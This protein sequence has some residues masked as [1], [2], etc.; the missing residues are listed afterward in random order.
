M[1]TAQALKQYKKQVKK[2]A[3]SALPE[4][5]TAL[6]NFS[7]F[8]RECEYLLDNKKFLRFAD[9]GEFPALS[10][11]L[12][13]LL[14]DG[15]LPAQDGLCRALAANDEYLTAS[16]DRFLRESILFLLIRTAA[17][18]ANQK[19][20]AL[21]KN[22]FFSFFTLRNI[23]FSA[24]TAACCLVCRIYAREQA[25]V[26]PAM[27]PA[28]KDFYILTTD[29]EAKRRGCTAE[30]LAEEIRALADS[31]GRHVGFYLPL[32]ADRRRA[33][34][35]I[36]A[37]S[38]LAGVIIAAA[39]GI[40][41]GSVSAALLLWL[42]ITAVVTELIPSVAARRVKPAFIPRME[43][44]KLPSA[45]K[46]TVIAVS[47]IVPAPDKT[48]QIEKHLLSLYLSQ[49]ACI[50]CVCLSADFAPADTPETPSDVVCIDALKRMIDRL[51]ERTGG[52]FVLAVRAR[53]Y[54]A[55][56]GK[57]IGKERKRG[58]LLALTAY[59]CT[60]E[61]G[62]SV[63]H[64]DHA[65]MRNAPYAMLLDADTGLP[66]GTLAQA[67][68]AAA[69]P[70]HQPVLRQDTKTVE[71]GYGIF[72]FSAVPSVESMSASIFSRDMCG[73]GGVSSYNAGANDFYGDFFADGIFCGKGLV[74][75]ESYFRSLK[76]RFPAEQMLSH[77]VAEGLVLRV[78][79]LTDLA[80]TDGFPRSETA[81]LQRAHRWMRGDVQNLR[82]PGRKVTFFGKKTKTPFGFAAR[83]KLFDNLR[84][85]VT[86][87]A[88]CACVIVSLFMG[89]VSACLL[90][91]AA[92]LSACSGDLRRGI[93][94][95]FRGGMRALS[96]TFRGDA[97]PEAVS[98]LIR[99]FLAVSRI[100]VEGL[101]AADAVI[102]SLW[103][104]TVSKKHLLEWTTAAAADKSS[105]FGRILVRRLPVLLLAA[106]LLLTKRPLS[107]VMGL[108]LLF[109][110]FYAYY[111]QRA[112]RS[113][114]PQF[115]ETQ[116]QYLLREAG[117]IWRYFAESFK[118]EYHFL[119]P[120]N[121]CI[122]PVPAVAERTSP[123]NIGLAMC[124]CLAARDMGFLDSPALADM[125]ERTVTTVE[126]LEKSNGNLLN[127]YDIKTLRP[128]SPKFVSFV[129]SG[130]F[131]CCLTAL[132]EGLYAY[133]AEEPR[134]AQLAARISNLIGDCRLAVFYN[135]A[136]DLFHT[137]YDADSG[138]YADSFYDLRISEARMSGYLAVAGGEVP[139]RHMAAA[140][141]LP[142]RCGRFTGAMSW[143]GTMFEYFMPYLFLPSHKNTLDDESLWFALKC[144]L[145]FAAGRKVPYG[146][147]ESCFFAF[148]SNMNYS[149]KAHG[150]DACAVRRGGEDETVI[151]P[152]STFL[153][154]P[155]AGGR[156]V[157]NLKALEKYPCKGRYGFFEALDFTKGRATD[158]E[159][160]IVRCFM[161]H[162]LGMS[163]LALENAL[164]QQIWQKRFTASAETASALDLLDER[165]PLGGHVYRERLPRANQ[166]RRRAA[167]KPKTK[168]LPAALYSNGQIAA[169]L[170]ES[171]CAAVR[172]HGNAVLRDPDGLYFSPAG[173]F[174]AVVCADGAFPFTAAPCG[175]E[176]QSFAAHFYEDRAC[177]ETAAPYLALKLRITVCREIPALIYEFTVKNKTKQK[178]QG[179]FYVY[180][181]PSLAAPSEEKAHRAYSKLFIKSRY[182]DPSGAVL[183]HRTTEGGGC[184]A[185]IGLDSPYGF[186][187]DKENVFPVGGGIETLFKKKPALDGV[188]GSVDCCFCGGSDFV[189]GGKKEL[190]FRL[191]IGCGDTPQE[192]EN[193]YLSALSGMDG[194]LA[195]TEVFR[196]APPLSAL[197]AAVLGDVVFRKHAPQ[198]PNRRVGTMP[199]LWAAGISGDLPLLAADCERGGMTTLRDLSTVVR[200]L[201]LC[202]FAVDLAAVYREDT[203]YE[204]P[205]RRQ[206]EKLRGADGRLF[207]VDLSA[208]PDATG[209]MI[210]ACAD[211]RYPPK[212]TAEE[213]PPLPLRSAAAYCPD[214][215]TNGATAA[216][217]C[218]VK[219][220]A[221][222][223]SH[224]LAN[225]MFGCLVTDRSLGFSWAI[226]AAENKLTPWLND[227]YTDRTGELL[228][229]C[230]AGAYTDIISGG[231]AIF[232][233]NRA[234]WRA[235]SGGCVFATELTVPARGMRKQLRVTVKNIG[236]QPYDGQVSYTVNAVM[237][238][239]TRQGKYA[240]ARAYRG[241]ILL[242]NPC[243]GFDGFLFLHCVDGDYSRGLR[244]YKN[245]G[246]PAGV[247]ATVPVILAPG[248]E[249][250]CVF[251]L[252]YGMTA[253]AAAYLASAPLPQTESVT[254]PILADREDLNVFAGRFLPMQIKRTRIYARCGLYQCSGA[255]GFRDQLQDC[256]NYARIDPTLLKLQLLRSA[257][258]QFAAGD[259]LHWF[260]VGLERGKQTV[261][262]VRTH[263]SDDLVWLPYAAAEYIALTGDAALLEKEI[264]FLADVPLEAH[265]RDKYAVVART[266]E[267]VTLYEH[268]LRA[269]RCAHRVGEHGL[270]LM[271]GGD[272]NDSFGAV[273]AEGKGESVWLTQFYALTLKKFSAVCAVRGDSEEK[274]RLLTLG[275][276]LL[277]AV[278]RA[279][280]QDDRYARAFYD[281]GTVMGAVGSGNT[282]IDLLPQAFA[283]LA[284]MK[285]KQRVNTA[286]MTAYQLLFD[287]EHQLV[288][289]FAPPFDAD[290]KHTG[291]V[292]HYPAGVREN[293]GQYTHAAVWF[294]LALHRAGFPAQ[295]KEIM[296][297]LNPMGKLEQD[298]LTGRFGNEPYALSADVYTLKNYEGRGGWSQYTGAA[299]WYL[300]A[301]MEIY[302]KL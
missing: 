61:N 31:E 56:E 90:L 73:A 68:A 110:L 286:L 128:L 106:C 123:T 103:R 172:Y 195:A 284:G 279:A 185:A 261:K 168:Q 83:Y 187:A 76:D 4:A 192:A 182:G 215:Q 89:R 174:A 293:G 220:P 150:I 132:K 66:F 91:A 124:A 270:L 188:T 21:M 205:K 18:A 107:A 275:D 159:P 6:D 2:Y 39:A 203:G 45:R 240:F 256:M 104:M 33:G 291:Y 189:L 210:L 207:P 234:V 257:A 255:Y 180:A 7:A 283:A 63:L 163:L 239:D 297:A 209:D 214:Q 204:K 41:T 138:K 125:L 114:E 226:N 109:D 190:C 85:A 184:A 81:Y 267:K 186:T 42:P 142:G 20:G 127:W 29:R 70:L 156:A 268:C 194:A 133:V 49:R 79:P 206:I 97:V 25:G 249:A 202:G 170:H 273:G 108:F 118:P 162:H 102:R 231:S 221:R 65:A 223:W 148:D 290:K 219:H 177:Y 80:L 12:E 8:Q 17:D 246:L 115:K 167:G 59:I 260:H 60:G 24:V 84:R 281:D 1:N 295:A 258:V 82:L 238:R 19:N 169:A 232:S 101:N 183:Y 143:S 16:E 135:N 51:N 285:D 35:A 225:S 224:C 122:S 40:F 155:F 52:G 254:V 250:R 196:D 5:E 235:C 137:G 14:P 272:W 99:A 37:V 152:Y 74:H 243:G 129:D 211:G 48:A 200:K 36:I 227:A 77:D 287:R 269:L 191:V 160:A 139:V 292:N 262:G 140:A 298:G 50:G 11:R 244:F 78:L 282:E 252:S 87:I 164:S 13:A 53:E 72:S 64:G 86:P 151:S 47:T 274:A 271:A 54:S 201:N 248:E 130:N 179:S 67:V 32:K 266:T 222:P 166:N 213:R 230:E 245:H 144:Q 149:Y 233:E 154:L 46:K 117:A 120:D 43:I 62:F 247:T 265:E 44:E 208:C 92:M 259:V 136:R 141:R 88:V 277:A 301:A 58:A 198:M 302:G 23:D 228:T 71:A 121:I 289:L 69:H 218:I 3:R 280:W 131:K 10:A 22:A 288:K 34:T 75:T 26:F 146:V 157:Q 57:Y 278:D 126:R 199:D 217:F 147:S 119:P 173:V 276:M 55:T 93:A 95:L 27:E 175:Q 100:G 165:I 299:G 96:N 300:T 153:T 9:G 294:A 212:T 253:D 94:E 38:L 158:G 296:Q 116:R 98:A 105:G 263:C 264:A 113:T 134:L 197:C 242:Q 111:S 237:G 30:A 216:G 193:H 145:R 161:S 251:S 181:E 28:T 15:V 176:R 112:V 236:T 229:A 241:G 171:G 178:Q